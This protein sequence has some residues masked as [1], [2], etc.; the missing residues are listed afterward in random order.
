MKKFRIIEASESKFKGLHF[1][2]ETEIKQQ[3]FLPFTDEEYRCFMFN[4][5]QIKLVKE[6]KY[7]LGVLY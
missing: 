6:D 1:K 4:G 5:L 2:A 7:I 3:V